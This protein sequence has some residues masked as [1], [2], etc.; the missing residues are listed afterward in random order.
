V[1]T[2][3][4]KDAWKLSAISTWEPTLLWYA[5]A[6]GEMSSRPATDPT[7]WR[8]Q[9]GIH[10][11][12]KN[13]DPLVGAGPIPKKSVTDVFWGQ[14]QH[15]TWF[16]LPWH[17]MYLGLFEQIVRATVVK[18][19]GPG[20]WALPFW[21]YSDA[22][23][24]NANALPPAFREAKLPDGSPNPLFTLGGVNILRAPGVNTGSTAVIPNSD[25]D[26][27][28]CLAK[29]IYSPTTD[30]TTGDLGFGGP[31][32]AANHDAHV[33][34]QRS[35]ESV[36]HNA[37]HVD[38]GGEWNQGGKTL[39][40]WMINPDTAAL[41]PIFWLHHA[42]IDRLWAVW[43]RASAS[44]TNPS[45][46]VNV[47]G[48]KITWATSIKFPFHNAAGKV[49]NMTPG[50]VIDTTAAPFTYE[51]EGLG[52][53]AK[54]KATKMAAAGPMRTPMAPERPEMIGAS[55]KKVTLT[56]ARQSAAIAIQPPTGPAKAKAAKGGPKALKAAGPPAAGKTYLHI[57][58]VVSKKSHATYE[59][60]V[61]LPENPDA[62]AYEEHHAGAMHLFGVVRASTRSA[63]S[64]G[65]GLTFS[66]DITGL[67]KA[68]K[69]KNAWDENTVR[70]SFVPRAEAE[71]SGVPAEHDPIKIGR[72]GI[73][74]A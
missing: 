56:G 71:G 3:I 15:G 72:I 10:G 33:F 7:S 47:A 1:A 34:G 65:N 55:A 32:T 64:A 48:R 39:D 67:V 37:I 2:L 28:G 73:Y 60:Y 38:V 30:T 58:N 36:P 54:P 5:K 14:C 57:E 74:R 61:N 42:N 8:F 9:A 43:N 17:R 63:G 27:T 12:S 24:P 44:H 11:Y 45:S 50:Q 62:A 22:S 21:N 25:V 29:T 6:V 46:P 26:L 51:Y 52:A 40:G 19:G 18:L 13:T 53:V 69:E 23:N 31:A 66:I 70:V 35:V 20:D 68:L 59:V 16:F 41:D 4:R 49:V